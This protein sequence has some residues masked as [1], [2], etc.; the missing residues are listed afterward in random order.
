MYVSIFLDQAQNAQ[1]LKVWTHFLSPVNHYAHSWYSLSR[2]DSQPLAWITQRRG[3]WGWCG[4]R[5]L[6]PL[7]GQSHFIPPPAPHWTMWCLRPHVGFAH[8][9]EESEKCSGQGWAFS[10]CVVVLWCWMTWCSAA[11]PRA[12]QRHFWTVNLL[13]PQCLRGSTWLGIGSHHYEG[14]FSSLWRKGL[15]DPE[16]DMWQMHIW[17][18]FPL[19]CLLF[20]SRM[21][22]R[23]H[24]NTFFQGQT[25]FANTALWLRRFGHPQLSC[26]YQQ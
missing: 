8:V 26:I 10:S 15:D 13:T 9:A 22:R 11:T 1:T 6:S 4:L 23:W 19:I 3:Q 20:Y 12:A 24:K 21:A 2:D 16:T 5:K 7:E 14:A 25:E 17:N 18:L